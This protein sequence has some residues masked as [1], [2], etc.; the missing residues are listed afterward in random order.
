[1]YMYLKKTNQ[2]HPENKSVCDSGNCKKGFCRL[3]LINS[4]C[5]HEKKN[6]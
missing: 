6:L 1:M 4:S 2:K 5:D 3:V